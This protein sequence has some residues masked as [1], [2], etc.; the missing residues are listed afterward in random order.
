MR[1]DSPLEQRVRA[2]IAALDANGL[3][4]TLREP[5]GIDLSSNDYLEPVEA[6]G[7]SRRG[8]S[9]APC[10]KDAAAPDRG[11]CGAS[12]HASRRSSAA[13]PGSRAPSGAVFFGGIPGEHRCADDAG[14]GRRR[15][16]LGRAQSRQPHRRHAVVARPRRRVSAQRCPAAGAPACRV[17]RERGPL[18]RRRIAVQHGRRRGAACRVCGALPILW[19]GSR[20]GRGARR[21]HL[22]RARQR[23]DG[24][25]RPRS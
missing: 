3:L 21:R 25:G 2:R 22:R 12:V 11:C 8:S 7:R 24:S 9:R 17:I 1:R 6:P 5:A 4:R 19:C 14:R 16:L 15:H 23:A 18:R 10:A 13:S 20:R